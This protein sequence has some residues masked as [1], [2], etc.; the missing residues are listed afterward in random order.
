MLFLGADQKP[1]P[2]LPIFSGNSSLS[3]DGHWLAYMS[4]DSGQNEVY[5]QP[6]PPTGAKYQISTSGGRNAL[7]SPDGKQLFYQPD[8]ISG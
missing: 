4:N 1:K 3:P 8:Q 2:L 5:V 7:W 6:F